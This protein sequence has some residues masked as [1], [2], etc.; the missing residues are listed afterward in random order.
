M[1]LQRLAWLPLAGMAVLACSS[2][3]SPTNPADA[4]AVDASPTA[5]DGP[6]AIDAASEASDSATDLDAGAALDA[7]SEASDARSATMDAADGDAG[8]CELY[9]WPSAGPDDTCSSPGYTISCNHC[10]F[11]DYCDIQ[12]LPCHCCVLA[13]LYP[14]DGGDAGDAASTD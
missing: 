13:S 2:T 8:L 11:G 1:D 10:G 6:T 14:P 5:P 4:S 7:A 9:G 3:S 12:G